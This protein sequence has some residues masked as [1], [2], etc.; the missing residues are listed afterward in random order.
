MGGC[1]AGIGKTAAL[2]V[3]AK[4][5]DEPLLRVFAETASFQEIF[6]FAEGIDRPTGILAEQIHTIS[7]HCVFN[8]V[9]VID[10]IMRHDL[11][12]EL[13]SWLP[14]AND[15]A[16]ASSVT[17][18]RST[19]LGSSARVCF[20]VDDVS[21]LDPRSASSVGIVHFG[22]DMLDWKVRPVFLLCFFFSVVY[23]SEVALGSVVVGH[24]SFCGL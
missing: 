3:F 5:N 10:G 4:S 7:P 8:G 12:S 1:G 13:E 24:N 9:I 19:K 18:Q 6:G 16:T 23:L 22:S 2:L 17:A 20:E 11:L 15:S 21:A 14:S